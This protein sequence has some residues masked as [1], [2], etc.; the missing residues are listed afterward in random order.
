[1]TS[2]KIIQIQN[3]S[4]Q[5]NKKVS[6]LFKHVNLTVSTGDKIVIRGA[7]G[8]GKTTLLRCVIGVLN[9]TAGKI[10]IAPG[11][12]IGVQLQQISYPELIKVAQIVTFFA[13]MIGS[14][15]PFIR[16]ADYFKYFNIGEI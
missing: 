16:K 14:T 7:N 4:Y 12:N 13:E 1:M 3:L 15:V 11:T 6:P 9:P 5:R 8:T 10:I 2:K